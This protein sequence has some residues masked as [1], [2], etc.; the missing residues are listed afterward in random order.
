M[1]FL[2]EKGRL[3]DGKETVRLAVELDKK[4]LCGAVTHLHGVVV[5]PKGTSDGFHEALDSKSL[6][7][8]MKNTG[9]L[10]Q[11]V[12]ELMSRDEDYMLHPEKV[13]EKVDEWGGWKTYGAQ[14]ALAV[15]EMAFKISAQYRGITLEEAKHEAYKAV[16]GFNGMNFAMP[17]SVMLS[18]G[19]HGNGIEEPEGKP[20]H[21][22]EESVHKVVK[23]LPWQEW[24]VQLTFCQSPNQLIKAGEEFHDTLYW[25][26]REKGDHVKKLS[27]EG[28]MT[29]NKVRTPF[30]IIGLYR[31]A[32]R[33]L[34]RRLRLD[35]ELGRDV[36]LAIDGA[37]TE[38][39]FPERYVYDYNE[40]T[41]QILR[42]VE[43]IGDLTI[44]KK[45]GLIK[46]TREQHW[47]YTQKVR[48]EK[49]RLLDFYTEGRY[50]IV[51]S[52]AEAEKFEAF[53]NEKPDELTLAAEGYRK[54]AL[55][56]GQQARLMRHIVDTS[57]PIFSSIEDIMSEDDWPGWQIA[58][59]IIDD[60]QMVGDDWWVTNPARMVRAYRLGIF[61]AVPLIK[62]N[63]VADPWKAILMIVLSE[64]VQ[65][66]RARGQLDFVKGV[67]KNSQNDYDLE[68]A[69]G[70]RKLIAKLHEKV[71]A[72]GLPTG[73]VIAAVVS[74]RSKSYG[75]DV[76]LVLA[77]ATGSTGKIGAI[78]S[79]K[80]IVEWLDNIDPH[81]PKLLTRFIKYDY[82][83]DAVNDPRNPTGFNPD[84]IPGVHWQP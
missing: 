73:P 63:Q 47:R 76:D 67:L 70:I 77:L 78:S 60:V 24:M 42:G 22:W 11:Q 61:N 46:L 2:V 43:E 6:E 55:T 18:A 33:R 69:A 25:L 27:K 32:V 17:Q 54:F 80:R 52:Q 39:Y 66:L 74:H 68:S 12:E 8:A 72:I 15:R 16:G 20:E 1:G 38:N 14:A 64:H 71:E 13:C 48:A 35:L 31:E 7:E 21:P 4:E 10:W 37:T 40:T 34:S 50:H 83:R 65:Y 3:S 81:D 84:S 9:E 75:P 53:L 51:L 49:G 19:K 36:H 26:L 28:G 30:E 56:S 23:G 57:G 58:S 45:A 41:E 79:G 44:D 59:G 62:E 5:P 29:V 82:A